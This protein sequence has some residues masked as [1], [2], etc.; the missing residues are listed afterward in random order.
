MKDIASTVGEALTATGVTADAAV[1]SFCIDHLLQHPEKVDS[2][3]I[4]ALTA[5]L[6]RPN[7]LDVIRRGSKMSKREVRVDETGE[8][9][10]LHNICYAPFLARAFR[11]QPILFACSAHRRSWSRLPTF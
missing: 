9:T 2:F 6:L 8:A 3:S 11:I 5:V 7:V 4:E 1:A 10:C